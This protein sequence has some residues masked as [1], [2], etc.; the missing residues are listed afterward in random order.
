[1]LRV[2]PG[3]SGGALFRLG[4][5]FVVLLIFF[6]AA[7]AASGVWHVDVAGSPAHPDGAGWASAYPDIQ[8]AIDAAAGAVAAG[9]QEVWVASGV[10]RSGADYVVKMKAQ[11]HLYGGFS[12]RESAIE[13]RNWA[14]NITIIDG[15]R[16]RSGVKGASTARLDGF[17][18]QHG[19]GASHGGGMV[20][21]AVSPDVRNCTFWENTA[22][23]SGGGMYNENAAALLENCVFLC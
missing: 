6:P 11:V 17:R 7:A 5:G 2:I 22:L 10:Y 13:E 19:R 4:A 9:P 3:N 12:G 15:E 16:R 21:R 20:N 18:I 1:M 8:S 23:L 14:V